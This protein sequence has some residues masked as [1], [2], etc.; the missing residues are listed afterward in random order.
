MKRKKL[1]ESCWIIEE[2]NGDFFCD[3]E[4]GFKGHLC[5]HVI[6]MHYRN[7]TGKIEES[8]QVRSLPLGSAR[9]AGRPKGTGHKKVHCLTK[10]PSRPKVPRVA[11]LDVST[12]VLDEMVV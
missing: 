6:G 7:K 4:A 12:E 9:G 10:S 2:S 1:R 5:D 8:E 11:A 3:C